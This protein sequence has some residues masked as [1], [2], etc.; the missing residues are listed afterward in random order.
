MPDNCTLTKTIPAQK[1]PAI[2][3]NRAVSVLVPFELVRKFVEGHPSPRRPNRNFPINKPNNEWIA[4]LEIAVRTP[5]LAELRELAA[6]NPPP[7]E[8]FE[9]DMECPW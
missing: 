8:Y 3:P 2:E 7:L 1:V 9:G 6:N 5:S 4:A